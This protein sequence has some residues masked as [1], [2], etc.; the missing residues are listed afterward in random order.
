MSMSLCF[1]DDYQLDGIITGFENYM[2]ATT[3]KFIGEHTSFDEEIVIVDNSNAV[4]TIPMADLKD[5]KM[6]L[7]H[8]NGFAKHRIPSMPKPDGL[9]CCM[10][11][12]LDDTNKYAEEDIKESYGILKD[13]FIKWMTENNR[14]AVMVQHFYQGERVPHVHILYQRENGRHSEFQKYCLDNS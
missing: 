3:E 12:I 6:A 4:H 1:A 10:V 11:D 7:A 2:F 5:R 9:S 8:F 14:V 13:M